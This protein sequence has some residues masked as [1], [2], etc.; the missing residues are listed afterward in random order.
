MYYCI[1]HLIRLLFLRIESKV[2]E[3]RTGEKSVVCFAIKNDV[4]RKGRLMYIY[5]GENLILLS[6][7]NTQLFP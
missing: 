1:N 2:L 6:P 3:K 4:V 5:I 7:Y